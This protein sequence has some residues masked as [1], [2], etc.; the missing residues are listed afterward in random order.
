MGDGPPARRLRSLGL[1]TTANTSA[2]TL[3]APAWWRRAL[4]AAARPWA[5]AWRDA[6][7]ALVASR[8][9]AW[10]AASLGV[11]LGGSRAP[12]LPAG[13]PEWLAA[14]FAHWDALHFA[15]IARHGYPAAPGDAW[16][17]LPGYPAAAR[18]VGEVVGSMWAGGVLVSVACFA[19]ALVL[20]GKL[21]AVE[22][23]PAAA[24]RAVWLMALF[25][26]SLFATAFYSEGLFLLASIGAVYAARRERWAWAAAAAAAATV[27][28]STGVLLLVPLVWLA[29]RAR[30]EVAGARGAALAGTAASGRAPSASGPLA[31]AWL[32]L[33]LAA[34]G[35]L[36]AYAGL[37]AGDAL[38]PWHAEDVWGRSFHGPFSAVVYAFGHPLGRGVFEPGWMG[39]L[40]LAFLALAVVGIL[41]ALLRLP[42]VYGTYAL[43]ALAAPLSAPWPDHPL[44]SF[45]RF[46]LGAFPVFMWLGLATRRRAVLGTVLGV[47]AV[48]L[49][50]LSARFGMWLWVA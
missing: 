16:A 45:P 41:G 13:I 3:P 11:V 33:P 32:L 47:F 19:G 44:M 31:L 40:G 39:P 22:C 25:P 24:R 17:F 36:L 28:R 1:S 21:V 10:A 23:G 18:A 30:R 4:G 14:P 48:A 8:V 29:W 37:H 2:A 7:L 49:I 9:V 12:G 35:A 15:G 5:P 6:A 34:L 50:F 42:A 26:A 46:L 27:T 38:A 20:L 43:L